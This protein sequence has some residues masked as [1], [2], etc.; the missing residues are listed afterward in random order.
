MLSEA[1]NFHLFRVMLVFVCEYLT[2][3]FLIICKNG[4]EVGRIMIMFLGFDEFSTTNY[5]N[6]V[7]NRTKSETNV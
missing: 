4:Q 6:G 5:E 7:V 2:H 1:I 3:P